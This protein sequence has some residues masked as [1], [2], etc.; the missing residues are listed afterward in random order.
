MRNDEPGLKSVGKLFPNKPCAS[1]VHHL[2]N[3]KGCQYLTSR[4]PTM[5]GAVVRRLVGATKHGNE[6]RRYDLLSPAH[7]A[8]GGALGT[9]AK[10][11]NKCSL[12][13]I[14]KKC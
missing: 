13:L 1:K 2:L 14:L 8:A 12:N 5:R 3:K 9:S 11:K 7:A 4:Q 10:E 6:N